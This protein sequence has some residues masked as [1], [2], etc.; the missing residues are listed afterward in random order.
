MTTR[1]HQSGF[2]Y[3]TTEV[4]IAAEHGIAVPAPIRVFDLD[5]IGI[6]RA[7]FLGDLTQSFRQLAWDAY[8][9]KREQVAF[10]L[11]NFPE[12]AERLKDFRLRYY[13][14]QTTLAE[15]RD[16]FRQLEHDALRKF[17]RIRS[18]RRRSI[19][20]FEVIKADDDIW[21]DQWHVAQQD[22]HGFSQNVSADD[23]RAIVRVFDPTALTVVGHREF[24]RLIVAVAE[25][26][27]DAETE[28]GRRVHGM[29]ATFHQMGLEVLADGVAPTMAPEG[30]HRDGADYIVSALVMERD[31]VEG[32]TS[33]VLS[34]DKAKTLLTVTL[35]P[36]QGIFQ[37]DALRS[38][39]EAEQLWHNV[40][41]VTL[42]DSDDD[43]RGSR[44]IFGFDVVLYR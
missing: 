4:E 1:R 29:T 20:K 7:R 19:A 16:L 10:L 15:L 26:V 2:T 33:T 5:G 43:Q 34:P 28:A 39:P 37:A 12:H 9:A 8:D 6:D 42:R 35:A 38:L 24:Q 36:G 21:S 25:M 27:E 41:P 11:R 14:G 32:G 13:A 18:Y 23:P 3:V 44:N 22:C 40:T 31:D 17:E 30:V